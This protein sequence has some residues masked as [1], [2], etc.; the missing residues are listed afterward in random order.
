MKAAEAYHF[1]F[2][3]CHFKIELVQSFEK[4]MVKP[5]GLI[6]VGKCAYEV[7]GIPEDERIAFTVGLDPLFKPQVQT[8]MK[9][10][11]CQYR[12]NNPTLRSS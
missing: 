5:L 3:C 11:I 4:F 2:L 8:K 1:G 12:R 10:D 6:A 9:V 7:I